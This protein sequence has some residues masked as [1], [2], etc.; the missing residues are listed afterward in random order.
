MANSQLSNAR[1]T[2]TTRDEEGGHDDSNDEA[3]A[4]LD[5]TTNSDSVRELKFGQHVCPEEFINAFTPME[6]EEVGTF[7]AG[8][9]VIDNLQLIAPSG[10]PLFY[11][12]QQQ[13]VPVVAVAM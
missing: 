13:L 8:T 3:H 6:F 7:D 1:E 4:S 2:I 9:H 12:M 5:N 10:S 11:T